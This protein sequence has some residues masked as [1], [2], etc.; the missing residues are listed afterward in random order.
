MGRRALTPEQKA[1]RGNPGK[2]PIRKVRPVR[3]RR[4][5]L[6][7]P[8]WL[9][10]KVAIAVWAKLQD[11]E[12]AIHFLRASDVHMFGR[13]CVYMAN[14]IEANRE[15]KKSG[16]AVYETTSAHVDMK[17]I[18][19]WFVVRS[20]LEDDLVKH[21]EKLGLTPLDRQRIVVQLAAAAQHPVGDLFGGAGAEAASEE[22]AGADMPLSS[23]PDISTIGGLSS[24]LN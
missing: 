20:R 11:G 6:A 18:N 5:T 4:A 24:R 15:I 1:A 3:I 23:G 9:T 7:R 17:R 8:S 14:W 13:Y 19:P 12:G 22:G 21:E 16:G 2:R 10:D